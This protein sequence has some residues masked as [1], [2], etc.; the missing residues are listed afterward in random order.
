MSESGPPKREFDEDLPGG[1][2]FFCKFTGRHF[3]N[4][5]AYEAHRKTKEFKRC[6]KRILHGGGGASSTPA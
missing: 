2:Q 3:E 5:N 1:G 4:E 6:R